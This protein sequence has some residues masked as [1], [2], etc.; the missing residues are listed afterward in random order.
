MFCNTYHML[1][2]PGPENVAKAGGLHKWINYNKPLITD[3]GGFQ[4]TITF[5]FNES[6][7]A[8]FTEINLYGHNAGY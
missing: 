7:V 2:H 1:I 8:H 5:L 4:V 3:S 6:V